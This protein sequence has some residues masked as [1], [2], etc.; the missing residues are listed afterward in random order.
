MH[1]QASTTS[2]APTKTVATALAWAGIVVSAVG[3]GIGL[4]KADAVAALHIVTLL[5][6]G[7]LGVI[8]FVR[9]A[10][11]SRSDAVRLG[12]AGEGASNFQRE[13]G[14]ANLAFGV[15]ALLAYFGNWGVPAEA[16]VTV[17]YGAYLLMT[18]VLKARNMMVDSA[19]STRKMLSPLAS[20]SIAGLLI[21][22]ALH[23]AAA[24][25]LWPA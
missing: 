20:F 16:A 25:G 21:Y 10:V 6:V 23:G 11:F 22:F 14:F 8:S 18:G 5:S 9:H 4:G 3:V 2:P 24:V 1:K 17:A 15:A 19:G 12:W 13:V 7:A